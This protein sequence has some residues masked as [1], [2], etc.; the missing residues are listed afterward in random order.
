[1][2]VQ[3]RVRLFYGQ[4]YGLHFESELEEGTTVTI[5]FPA[6]GLELAEG[7]DQAE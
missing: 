2:N 7:R 6:M 3:E 5:R 4:M 1:M